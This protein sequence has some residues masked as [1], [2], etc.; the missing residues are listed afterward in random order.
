MYPS[1]Y[2][3][4]TSGGSTTDR[5]TC[6]NKSIGSWS[7]SSVND[8][9]NNDWLFRYYQWTLSPSVSSSYASTVITVCKAGYVSAY[10]AF[11]ANDVRP[12]V[13]LLPSVVIQSGDGSSSNPF[14]LSEK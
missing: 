6:L 13:Y 4:A 10:N 5:A 2:G 9:K 11:S 7:N 12:V 14:I 8:C 3:Y 1:D